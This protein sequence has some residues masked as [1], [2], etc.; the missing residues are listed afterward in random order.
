M[1]SS[2]FRNIPLLIVGNG[3]V[4]R[5]FLSVL[6][7]H[8]LCPQQHWHRSLKSEFQVQKGI[9]TIFLAVS[10]SAL[11]PFYEEHL[12][13]AIDLKETEIYH[14]SGSVFHPCMQ[15]FH[16][17]AS[18]GEIPFSSAEFAQIPFVSFFSKCGTETAKI[19]ALPYFVNPVFSMSNEQQELYHSLC[20]LSG[21]YPN[22]LITAALQLW[23]NELK[24]PSGLLLGYIQ[25]TLV[26]A[27]QTHSLTSSHL[28]EVSVENLSGPLWR[29]DARTIQMN[30][31][32]L[33]KALDSDIAP[34]MKDIVRFIKSNQQRSKDRYDEPT[35][36][37]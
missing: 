21:N 37:Y 20:V 17:L 14:F 23:Q 27:L 26:A 5:Q 29:D 13:S 9:Q 16:I 15:G 11:I 22:Y 10:D 2:S 28:G 30:S 12:Q 8:G 32:I 3:K 31:Q 36:L 33:S 34:A 24:L 19:N 1:P 6:N 18:V 35:N 25:R 7:E 4:A